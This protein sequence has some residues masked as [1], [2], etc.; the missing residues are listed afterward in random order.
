[1]LCPDSLCDLLVEETNRYAQMIDIIGN[2]LI[3]MRYGHSLPLFSCYH[4][5]GSLV[6]GIYEVRMATWWYMRLNNM[7][8][9]RCFEIWKNWH[10]VDNSDLSPGDGSLGMDLSSL[11]HFE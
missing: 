5:I 8:V 9:N 10:V 3:D 7:S 11:T 1:M 4:F 6:L 2:M